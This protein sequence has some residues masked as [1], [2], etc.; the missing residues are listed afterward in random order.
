[1]EIIKIDS[2]ADLPI[3]FTGVAEYEDSSDGRCWFLKGRL[4]REDGPAVEDEFGYQ[5]W[6]Y[7]GKLHREDGPAVIWPSGETEWWYEGQNYS[8]GEHFDLAINNCFSD[9]E[10]M[11]LLFK[12]HQW[13]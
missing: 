13:K 3:Q 12:V 7:N 1:M 9:E 4:H 8:A 10:K 2:F 5:E 6:Y 11:A